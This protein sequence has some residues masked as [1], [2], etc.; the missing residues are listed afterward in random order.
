MLYRGPMGGGAASGA[1]GALVASHNSAGQYLRARTTPTDPSS[2]YQTA[3]RNAVGQMAAYW[4][5][6]L[7]AAQRTAWEVYAASVQ[8]TNALG[9]PINL[10]GIAMFIR[11][12]VPRLQSGMSVVA[13]GPGT[14]TLGNFGGGT[15]AVGASASSGT[16][17][18]SATE[19]WNGSGSTTSGILLYASKPQSPAVNFFKGP[20]RYVG[21]ANSST[22]SSTFTLP[23]NS[24]PTGQ[25]TFWQA[26][27]SRPDGRLTT[28]FRGYSTSP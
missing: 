21:R 6:T 3:V 28:A 24:G 9:D 25:K 26:R 14:P 17:T 16:L 8:V 13:A 18:Y 10:S 27:V 5:T 19:D 11:C 23:F 4:A 12:N 22:G 15:L 2:V 20:Y 1:V 7:T